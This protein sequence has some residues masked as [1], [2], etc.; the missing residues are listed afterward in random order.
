MP[1]CAL[2]Q[3]SALAPRLH[4]L[5]FLAHVMLTWLAREVIPLFGSH[6][7]LLLV[8]PLWDERRHSTRAHSLQ[9]VPGALVMEP[10]LSLRARAL[11]RAR[12]R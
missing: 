8:G 9:P 10:F 3:A 2:E 6:A 4:S 7:A 1:C 12:W 11:A 5:V